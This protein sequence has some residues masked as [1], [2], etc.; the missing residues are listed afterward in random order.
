MFGIF[1][2][3]SNTAVRGDVF[4]PLI[5]ELGIFLTYSMSTVECLNIISKYYTIAKYLWG[6]CVDIMA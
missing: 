4:G 6:Y 5:Q 1:H 2:E 3:T